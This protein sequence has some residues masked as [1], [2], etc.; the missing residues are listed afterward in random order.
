MNRLHKH[1]LT[2]GLLA[3]LAASA[4]AQTPAPAGTPGR[5]EG[6]QFAHRAGPMDP[7]RMQEH[8]ARME[9]RMA[10]RMEFFKFKLKVTPAQEG[11]WS[12]WTGAMKPAANRP[13]RPDR[14]EFQRLSTPERIDRMRAMRT[15]R[16]AE[17]DKKM[18]ATKAFYAVL[19]ADQKKVF[20]DA[21]LQMLQRHGGGRGGRGEGGERHHRG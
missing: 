15:A 4:L 3:G 1:L 17:M 14:A 13:P 8:R 7:A 11:A 2:A 12:A 21:S 10:E 18:D 20:D 9:Q 19:N 5:A 6:Q 16:Q